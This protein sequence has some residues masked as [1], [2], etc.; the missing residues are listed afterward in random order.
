MA[1]L[2]EL[3]LDIAINPMPCEIPNAV[4]FDKDLLHGAYDAEAVPPVLA[5]AAVASTSAVRVSAPAFSAKSA[6]CIFSGARSIWR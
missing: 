3:G 1:A 4:P 5:R 6:R 2:E